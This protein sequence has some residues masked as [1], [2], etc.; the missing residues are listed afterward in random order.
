MTTDGSPGGLT[1][2]PDAEAQT[3]PG[4]RHSRTLMLTDYQAE[5]LT[6]IAKRL[7]D[8][9]EASVAGNARTVAE[10]MV[11]TVPG[12]SI[13]QEKIGPFYEAPAIAKW[14]GVSRQ[15][16]HKLR[17]QGVL[18]A[19]QTADAKTLL[20]P[21]WQFGPGGEPLPHLRQ[22]IEALLPAARDEWSQAL[23]L[24]VKTPRFGGRSAADLLKSNELGPVLD[25]ARNDAARL[26]P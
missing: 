22:V 7:P 13:W 17:N 3:P 25:A 21:A 19:V 1:M 10:R 23:W 5:L 8:R 16:V 20:F 14:K 12:T 4:E 6:E 18:L 2:T 9:L 24:N 11:A 26:V 15:H